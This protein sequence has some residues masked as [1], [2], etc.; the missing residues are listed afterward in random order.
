MDNS[1]KRLNLK[2]PSPHPSQA[3]IISANDTPTPTRVLNSFILKS[4]EVGLFDNSAS[5]STQ[6]LDSDG[7]NNPFAETF[8]RAI[9]D[10]VTTKD[11]NL[12][13]T[14]KYEETSLTTSKNTNDHIATLYNLGKTLLQSSNHDPVYVQK[15]TVE[16]VPASPQQPDTAIHLSPSI[17]NPDHMQINCNAGA[18]TQQTHN[19][20]VQQQ[21]ER[22]NSNV[23][24]GIQLDNF[25]TNKISNDND[26]IDIN[27]TSKIYC[28]QQHK[29]YQSLSSQIF[30]QANNSSRLSRIKGNLVAID[31]GS[32]NIFSPTQ[33]PLILSP[34]SALLQ[35]HDLFRII[36]P[37]RHNLFSGASN[38]DGDTQTDSWSSMSNPAN[39]LPSP[40]SMLLLQTSLQHQHQQHH[41]HNHQ[42]QQGNNQQQQISGANQPNTVADHSFQSNEIAGD[43]ISAA[44]ILN[45]H[46]AMTGADINSPSYMSNQ[47]LLQQYQYQQQ[48]SDQ[49]AKHLSNHNHQYPSLSQADY[50]QVILKQ[51]TALY[52]DLVHQYQQANHNLLFSTMPIRNQLVQT[53]ENANNP[54]VGQIISSAP[55][56][57]SSTSSKPLDTPIIGST[58]TYQSDAGSSLT[59]ATVKPTNLVSTMISMAKNTINNNNNSIHPSQMSQRPMSNDKN[60]CEYTDETAPC[61]HFQ[62]QTTQ[63]LGTG[64]N[65]QTLNGSQQQRSPMVTDCEV[66]KGDNILDSSSFY[67][68]KSL[69]GDNH[70]QTMVY[71]ENSLMEKK[72]TNEHAAQQR[73]KQHYEPAVNFD[74]ALTI[75]DRQQNLTANHEKRQERTINTVSNEVHTS[76]HTWPS[77]GADQSHD[78]FTILASRPVSLDQVTCKSI[79]PIH[80][81]Q[82]SGSKDMVLDE[83]SSFP[84][85]RA[86]PQ[87]ECQNVNGDHLME[88]DDDITKAKDTDAKKFQRSKKNPTQAAMTQSDNSTLVSGLEKA[89]INGRPVTIIQNDSLPNTKNRDNIAMLNQK[90][91]RCDLEKT[92]VT[93]KKRSGGRRR[94]NV[95][96]EELQARKNRS[97]ERNRVAAKRCRQKRKVFI[98]ELRKKTDNLDQLNQRLQV[99]NVGLHTKVYKLNSLHKLP[100]IRST[101]SRYHLMIFITKQMKWNNH[102]QSS[103]RKHES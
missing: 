103:E 93:I 30:S 102:T 16:I 68:V 59:S 12:I 51:Q 56:S 52:N 67:R 22:N 40:G 32:P 71:E 92:E 74:K 57:T 100:N 58:N 54:T 38:Y 87:I 46:Q 45:N 23:Q 78:A 88:R 4:K 41:H 11:D 89:S 101:C 26:V 31:L 77:V 27:K 5:V 21:I 84:A 53:A 2:V 36:N 14:S 7:T 94:R 82:L 79:P 47:N 98:D 42:Q 99:S 33:S 15:P 97:K 10:T 37:S 49:T 61:S 19:T 13:N 43:Q 62:Q 6:E 81:E 55:Q 9:N 72:I 95:T 24:A 28:G 60:V 80:A 50:A 18:V 25:N 34:S 3:G 63:S 75:L 48:H 20:S 76:N 29:D 90:A 8:K 64:S 17:I 39:S 91:T 85:T 96:C 70:N 83:L 69:P 86:V 1:T 73:L 35:G 65:S 66:S 44:K